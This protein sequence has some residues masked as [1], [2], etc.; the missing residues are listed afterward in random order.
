MVAKQ[1]FHFIDEFRG[2]I[3]IMM[4]LGHSN[5]YFNH[6]WW[7]L[8]PLDPFFDTTGQFWLRYMGYLCAPGFLM[9]NGAMVYYAYW[10]RI[11]GGRS[12]A[13]ARWDFI[14]RGLFLIA[15][16]LLW[17][18]ASWSGFARLRLGHYGI[19][20]TIGTSMLILVWM[21][22]WRWQWRLLV[23]ALVFV[24]HPLLL[25][26]PYDHHGWAHV[27]MQLL[28]DAGS[29]NKYPV[30]PWFALACLGSVLAHF[31]F[32]VWP[33]DP[34][35]ARNSMLIG[36]GLVL[37]A[38]GVR[39]FGGEWGNLFPHGRFLSWAFCLV[40][41]YPPSPAHQL[42]FAGAVIFMVGLFCRVGIH[43]KW[44]RPLS[45][46]GRVPLFFYVVHIPL[47]AIFTRRL[48]IYY[49]QGAVLASF[50]GLAG[51]LLVMLPAARWFGGVKRRYAR[52]NWLIRMM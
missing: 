6:V 11:Q 44:L 32:S 38:W 26:I 34:T 9:M 43:G 50:V 14:Q 45:T 8:D 28:V 52:T 18:N 13:G 48:G 10:R 39:W 47:L 15:V 30:L 21:V 36:I 20:A 3:G 41:K 7:S 16:Q 17:V 29:F 19:I 37:A 46:V 22:R 27:P 33:D 35:R 24:V 25:R 12:H 1:R 51:L 2:L 4:A 49:R 40:Q 5:Y 42:W 23:A 31:W